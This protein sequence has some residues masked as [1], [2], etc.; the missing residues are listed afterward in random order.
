MARPRCGTRPAPASARRHGVGEGSARRRVHD[1]L[2][3]QRVEAGAGAV[4]GVAEGVDA[5]ARAR[6]RL[7]AGEHAAGRA[8]RC[9]RR[10]GLDVHAHLD[11]VAARRGRAAGRA[12]ARPATRRPPGAAGSATRSTPVTSSVTVCSTCRR[13]LASMKKKRSRRRRRPGTRRCRRSGSRAAAPSRTAASQ[14]RGRASAGDSDGD[15]RDLDQLLVAPLERALALAQVD[16]R[17]SR[18]RRSAPRCGA[19]RR[20]T[21]RRRR[22]PLPNAACASDDARA[23]ASSSSAGTRHRPASRG[24]R[25]RRPP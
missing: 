7:E 6:R 2:G 13:G 25:R 21:A 12:R 24:R 8:G 1:H 9:R 15:G 14:Q 5:H 17:P 23:S 22:S 19:P 4:A 11:R 3:Q 10:H 16:H 20:D 18:R